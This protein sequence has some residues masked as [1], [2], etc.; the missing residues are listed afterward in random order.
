MNTQEA[1]AVLQ[2]HLARYRGESYAALWRLLGAPETADVRG[3]SGTSYQIEVQAAWDDR[4]GG[5]LRVVGGIDDR[6]WR[7]FA[8]MTRSFIVA[9]DGSLVGE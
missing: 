6:G 1:T 9:P 7:E 8:P 3:P 2:S 4:P 5:K